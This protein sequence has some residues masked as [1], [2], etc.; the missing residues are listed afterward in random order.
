MRVD[1]KQMQIKLE[2]LERIRKESN[3]NQIIKL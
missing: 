2:Q 1:G 3:N